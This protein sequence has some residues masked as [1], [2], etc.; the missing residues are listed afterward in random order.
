MGMRPTHNGQ[1]VRAARHSCSTMDTTALLS[2]SLLQIYSP[3]VGTVMRNMGS[4]YEA[5]GKEETK[6]QYHFLSLC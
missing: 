3:R 5:C 4:V 2:L 1:K 6:A